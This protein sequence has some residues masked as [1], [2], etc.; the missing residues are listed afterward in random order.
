MT[1]PT[2]ERLVA[3]RDAARFVGRADELALLELAA[4]RRPAV[5]GRARARA[6][7][8][9]QERA[10]A[11]LRPPRARR[12]GGPCTGSTAATSCP[13]PARSRPRSRPA[14]ARRGAVVLLDTYE[15]MA[16]LDTYVRDE[17]LAAAARRRGRRHRRAPRARR[18]L[19][20]GRLGGVTC[21]LPLAPLGTAD[22][23]ALL[24]GRGVADRA[25]SAGWRPGR[26]ARRWRSRSSPA[27]PAGPGRF[28]PRAP[29]RRRDAAAAAG[30]R[31]ARRAPARRARRRRQR[32]QRHARRSC[33]PTLPGGD[34]DDGLPLARGA[35][36]RR[37]ARGGRRAARPGPAHA[38]R[39]AARPRCPQREG[40]LRRR[41]ADHL[42][43][44][45]RRR[46]AGPDDRPRRPGRRT[47]SSAP[48]TAGRAR[49]ATGSTASVPATRR[50]CGER[51]EA[52]G[53]GAWWPAH[54]AVVR[55]GA[56]DGL[57]RARPRGPPV[58]LLDRGHARRRAAPALATPTRCSAPGSSTRGA[59]ATATPC[60]GARRGTS[61]AIRARACRRWWRCRAS[62]ARGCPNPR[63]AYLPIDPAQPAARAFSRAL[64]GRR[65][66]GLDVER[67][68]RD[69]RGA[70]RR[71][72]TRRAARRPARPRL[73][74]ARPA[75]AGRA[76][77]RPPTCAP[78]SARC[79]GP[80]RWRRSPLARGATP[81]ERAATLR[82]RL[83]AA[84][85]HAFGEARE[86]R[87]LRDVLVR[88]YLA[89][90]R[91][92]SW[93]PTSCT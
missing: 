10:A 78:R 57:D 51:L 17:L 35:L 90:R 9:R 58:R 54:R 20:A 46:R 92:T 23:D 40:E 18:G 43:A 45:R 27:R 28:A 24:A 4:R 66:A 84:I 53:A 39:G 62:C 83:E 21:E 69:V 19:V 93:P 91:P 81:Q 76:V 65:L 60:C 29:R 55:A 67:R 34:A 56:R 52:A 82:A 36:V 31:G 3:E 48:A 14:R 80:P 63:Y 25:A 33:A 74:R 11:G 5:P 89:P 77:R 73:P 87:A 88:S 71:L 49:C 13:S 32:A 72:G 8:D 15:R 22:A 75:G 61:P 64:G 6:G 85:E 44:A 42:H 1:P 12:A 7:R 86:D 37:A 47:R 16:A 26:P 50:R 68:Q 79:T 59:P 2:L 41:L 30:R 38:A 70:P